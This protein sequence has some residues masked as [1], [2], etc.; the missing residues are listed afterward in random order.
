MLNE[1][2]IRSSSASAGFAA[3]TPPRATCSTSLPSHRAQAVT[4]HD[5]ADPSHG[6]GCATR[7]SDGASCNRGRERWQPR[8]GARTGGALS[9][10]AQSLYPEQ[11]AQLVGELRTIAAAIGDRDASSG[12]STAACVTLYM[13]EFSWCRARRGT[14]APLDEQSRRRPPIGGARISDVKTVRASFTQ[15]IT[16]PLSVRRSLGW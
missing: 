10:G 13:Q 3:S 7:S 2:T 5:L 4:T 11:F 6:T 16:N 9:D 14:V 8:R 1:G 12:T 15:T